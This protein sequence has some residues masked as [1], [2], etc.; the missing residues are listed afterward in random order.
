MS[1]EEDEVYVTSTDLKNYLFCPRIVYFHK[2]MGMEPDMGAQQERSSRLH[3]AMAKAEVR[4]VGAV[5]YDKEMEEALKEFDVALSSKNLKASSRVDCVIK[6]KGRVIPVDYKFSGSRRGKPY[7]DHKYQ[8][9]LHAILLEEVVGKPVTKGYIYY[10]LD[11]V[12]APV[13]ITH[14]MKDYVKKVIKTIQNMV[15]T[16][17]MPS[18]IVN[19]RKCTG[20]CGY[21][22]LCS[23]T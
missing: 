1:S 17:K 21:K 13:V 4:R 10:A 16:E 18:T 7:S 15:E 8:L 3:E 20:G 11:K 6:S 5:L 9:T 2:I 19:P 22:N 14:Q 23:L 12:V